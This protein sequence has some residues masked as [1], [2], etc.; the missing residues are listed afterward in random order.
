MSVTTGSYDAH[1]LELAALPGMEALRQKCPCRLMPEGEAPYR[2]WM[3]SDCFGRGWLPRPEAERLGAL[4]EAALDG[5]YQRIIFGR[6]YTEDGVPGEGC[7]A[8]VDY[9][10]AGD[11]EASKPWQAMTEAMWAAGVAPDASGQKREE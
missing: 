5:G 2:A 7:W 6:D 11:G 1:Y 4:V 3:C 9:S 10:E 8:N